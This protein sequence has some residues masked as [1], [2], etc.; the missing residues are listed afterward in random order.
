MRDTPRAPGTQQRTSISPIS[1]RTTSNRVRHPN[2][3]VFSHIAASARIQ[4]VTGD[5]TEKTLSPTLASTPPTYFLTFL[6]SISAALAGRNRSDER[7]KKI[8][9]LGTH[10][11]PRP[12]VSRG[13][14]LD[15]LLSL[16]NGR[17]PSALAPSVPAHGAARTAI[18]VRGKPQ[19]CD[20]KP[21]GTALS[22]PPS[23]WLLCDPFQFTSNVQEREHPTFLSCSVLL[24]PPSPK[25]SCS[26]SFDSDS[27]A[28]DHCHRP[29]LPHQPPPSSFP[30]S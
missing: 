16:P 18:N 27:Q 6:A 13:R 29:H 5:T 28:T 3:P 26:P 10:H 20:H 14:P 22:L 8:E 12:C 4:L 30:V 9:E 23:P 24:G 21:S 1:L 19:L 7:E 25:S 11:R 15:R 17:D 2:S